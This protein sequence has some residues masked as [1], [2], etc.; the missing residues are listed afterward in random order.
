MDEGHGQNEPLERHRSDSS[1]TNR[2]KLSDELCLPIP[3]TTRSKCDSVEGHISHRFKDIVKLVMTRV[4]YLDDK[5]YVRF[6]TELE[7]NKE[8][9]AT[10]EAKR[11]ERWLYKK[12]RKLRKTI[13]ETGQP[14]EGYRKLERRET[15]NRDKNN[16]PNS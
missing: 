10:Y 5:A 2:R 14:P 16:D 13:N 7:R 8:L 6:K 12:S 1:I 3:N 11:Q 15:Q 9:K 4:L